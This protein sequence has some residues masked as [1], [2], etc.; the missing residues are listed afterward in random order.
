MHDD[1]KTHFESKIASLIETFLHNHPDY[2]L[3]FT[4]HSLGGGLATGLYVFW[5]YYR[6]VSPLLSSILCTL[7]TFAAPTMIH[8]PASE[9]ELLMEIMSVVDVSKMYHF[10][11]Q[12]DIVPRLLGGKYHDAT[13]QSVCEMTGFGLSNAQELKNYKALGHF[14][15]LRNLPPSTTILNCTKLKEKTLEA[16]ISLIG[17]VSSL[18]CFL[19]SVLSTHFP[20]RKTESRHY[21]PFHELL[22]AENRVVHQALKV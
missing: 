9:Q 5:S 4:G 17:M 15:W 13:M 6:A 10:V 20:P 22:P 2:Q 1:L 21:R 11:N 7:I 12:Y 18:F 8:S 16:P 19:F 3:V 14:L